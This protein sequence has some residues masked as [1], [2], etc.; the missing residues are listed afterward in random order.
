M[1]EYKYVSIWGKPEEV[2]DSLNNYG[3]EGWE[4]IC[5]WNNWHYFKRVI[6]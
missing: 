6:K 3:K 4:L 5:V 1:Y 2:S